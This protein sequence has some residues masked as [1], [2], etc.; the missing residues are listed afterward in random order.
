MIEIVK[1]LKMGKLLLYLI[2]ALLIFIGCSSMKTLTEMK[3][4]ADELHYKMLTIDTHTDTPLRFYGRNYDLS[5][6]HDVKEDGSKLDFPRMMEGGLDAVFFAAFVGQGSLTDSA[7]AEVNQ[8]ATKIIDSIY[9]N[10]QKNKDIAELAF[11]ADDAYRIKAEGKRA[12]YIGV[13]NGYAIGRD[14]SLIKKFYEKGVRYITLCHTQNNDL[15]DSSTDPDSLND[16]GL[17]ELGKEAVTEMNN[18]GMMI[19]ISHASDKTFYDVLELSRTPIIASHSCAKALCN[20]PR[21]LDDDM[22]KKLAEK[23][24]VIQ[25][26]IY[27]EYVKTPKPNPVRDSV[28]A[29]LDAR[30]PDYNDRTEEQKDLYRKEKRELNKIYPPEL[31]TVSDV[32]DHI[33][34]IVNIAGIDHIG[35]GTDFDGGGGVE[36]CFDASEMKNITVELLKRGYSDDDIEKIWGGNFMRVFHKVENFIKQ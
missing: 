19:D 35:I 29:A 26:C 24:G 27:S 21:N 18:L 20:H 28:V 6:R 8:T 36:G 12:I 16:K 11:T 23:D 2:P 31:A 10:V 9:S 17:S 5:V 30:Y 3:K 25:L 32:V 33:D 22:L 13:E 15:C 1:G 4:T 7:Y 14:I 34:H